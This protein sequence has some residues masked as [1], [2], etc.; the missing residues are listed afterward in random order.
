MQADC[1]VKSE[2]QRALGSLLGAPLWKCTRAADMTTFQFGA[3]IE[4]EDFYKRPREV[5]EYALHV[6][7]DRRILR[8]GKVCVASQDLYYPAEYKEGDDREDYDWKIQPNCRDKLLE[9]LFEPDDRQF[10]TQRIEVGAAGS[11]RVEFEEDVVLEV[12]PD[13]SLPHEHWRLLSPAKDDKHFVVAGAGVV[14]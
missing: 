3:R 14:P 8:K 10:V 12:F 13:D 2:I 7:C 5:G 9:L 11:F 4:T 1:P 6:Q